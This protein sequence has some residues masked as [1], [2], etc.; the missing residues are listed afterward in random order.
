MDFTFEKSAIDRGSLFMTGPCTGGGLS[1]GP[2]KIP[3]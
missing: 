2:G 3:M 1:E